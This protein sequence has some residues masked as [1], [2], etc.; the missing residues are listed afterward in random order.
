MLN[1]SILACTK[2]ELWDLIVCIAINGENFQSRA[3][4]MTLVQ[5]CPISKLSRDIFIYFDYFLSY[6]AKTQKHGSME[7]HTDSDK[8]SI[9]AF[10]KNA[11]III[12]KS[13]VNISI[14]YL[15]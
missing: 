11:T 3:M 13:S 14:I 5:R 6:Y 15:F 9:V 12:I 10:G 1:I 8:Y 2:V 7:T 4:T